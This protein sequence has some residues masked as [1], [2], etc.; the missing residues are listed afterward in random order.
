MKDT[1]NKDKRRINA[2]KDQNDYHE[3]WRISR[4]YSNTIMKHIDS[5]DL[6][7]MCFMYYYQYMNELQ[8]NRFDVKKNYTQ[9]WDTMLNTVSKGND[10]MKGSI[11]LLHQTNVQRTN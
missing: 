3:A 1:I 6:Y 7:D 2:I 5:E 11:R 10:N 4:K 9:V 8:A